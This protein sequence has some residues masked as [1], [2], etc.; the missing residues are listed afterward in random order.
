[1]R[2]TGESERRALIE[3]PHLVAAALQRGMEARRGPGRPRRR[4]GRRKSATDRWRGMTPVMLS[5]SVFRAHRRRRDA[6]GDRR[7]NRD[8]RGEKAKAGAT[9][10]FL[11]GVQDPSNVGAIL[12]SA[13]AFGVGEW[14]STAPAPTPGR[15]R[16][17]APAWA[18]ISR[19]AIEVATS[20]AANLQAFN[21][22]LVC[23]VPRGGVPLGEADAERRIGLDLRRRGSAG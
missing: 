23:T 14:C 21:G 6:A 20:S 18:G 11:E 12:R 3:G 17:C 5:K 10:V 19:S 15:P 7:G 8:S 9:V 16:R 2:A 1:M 13:A 4:C 22:T